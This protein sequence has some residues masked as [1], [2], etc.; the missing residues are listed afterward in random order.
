MIKTPFKSNPKVESSLYSYLG[1][2]EVKEVQL[3]DIGA[4]ERG[5]Q[6]T[7]KILE[8]LF[9]MSYDEFISMLSEFIVSAYITYVDVGDYPTPII[10]GCLKFN[11]NVS[12]SLQY[13]WG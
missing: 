4:T 3:V 12:N 11:H 7:V 8:D 10:P 9:G 2:E 13:T 1:G 5:R 6:A